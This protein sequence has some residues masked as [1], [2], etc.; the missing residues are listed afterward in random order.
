MNPDQR[1]AVVSNAKYL[2]SVRPLDPEEIY[3]YV[4]GR[5]H[6]AA[7]KRVL[8]E[9]APALGLI[10]RD[11]GTFVPV[12]EG[13]ASVAHH[14]VEAF[15]ERYARTLEDLLVDRF[16]AGWPTGTGGDRLRHRIRT[17]KEAYLHGDAVEYDDLT[18]LAYAV[19]H[20]PDYYATTQYV[21]ADLARD[22][23]LPMHLRVLDVGAGVGG[24]A[25]GLADL[26]P[27]DALVEYHA[28][29]PGAAADVL[30]RMVAETG[31]NVHPTIHRETAEG[32]DPTTLLDGTGGDGHGDGDD[33]NHNGRNRD[34]GGNDEAEAHGFDLLLF[35][36]V[37]SEL[38]DPASVLLRYAE[39]LA[40]DGTA[41]ALAPADRNTA[42]GLRRVE[43]AVA[44]DGPLTV[45]APTVRLWPS[46]TPASDCWS[47]D[48]QPDL[49][50]PGFQ[51]CLDEGGAGDGEFVNVDVQYAYSMLRRDGRRGIDVTLDPGRFARMADMETHV[52]NRI[53]LAAIKLSHD[54]ADGEDANPLY[55]VG[56][57]SEQVDHFAVCTEESALNA[58]LA[59]ADYGDLLVF[60]N[61][62]ALWNDDERAYNLVVDGETVVDRG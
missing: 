2:R 12:E 40:E 59:T 8:E 52:T 22:G 15:P 38:D 37:L 24:P 35:A 28:V 45:Y 26:L 11:D 7:V 49:A 27:E 9:Q 58:D 6:P 19:Y 47:F 5:P 48:V 31:R 21:L 61:V 46:A 4:E 30:A 55:L 1:E 16:G 39:V 36:N 18:A 43:R 25:L 41:V 3:E 10:E 34:G 42:I 60:E 33:G 62:L 53:D 13:P 51:K 20:L 14:G 57:G 50:V 17:L 54:L 32:F 56:D 23:L 44:D 29:E